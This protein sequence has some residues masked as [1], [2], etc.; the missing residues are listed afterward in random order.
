MCMGIAM[1]VCTFMVIHQLSG[2]RISI[3]IITAIGD[4]E[5]TCSLVVESKRVALVSV[6][7]VSPLLLV[8]E[9]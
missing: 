6:V 7:F 1:T 4:L 2:F 3:F 9:R 5:I 8:A